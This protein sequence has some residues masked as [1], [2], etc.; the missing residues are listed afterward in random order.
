MKRLLIL[1]ITI[2]VWASCSKGNKNTGET[3]SIPLMDSIDTTNAVV[4]Y[5]GSFV[6][7]PGESVAGKATVLLEGSAYKLA[8]ENMAIGNGPDLHVYLAKDITALDFIDLG[9]L[10]STGGNQV[11]PIA[12]S[13]NFM[14]YKYALIYCQQYNVLFGSAKLN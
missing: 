9:V 1:S 11:Y 8:L 14:A 3:S 13:P 4:K 7:A 12:G 10:R 2:I 5:T 6:S